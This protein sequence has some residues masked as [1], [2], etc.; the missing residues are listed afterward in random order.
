M[1]HKQKDVS[2]II[3]VTVIR[4]ASLEERENLMDRLEFVRNQLNLLIEDIK[5]KIKIVSEQVANQVEMAECSTTIQSGINC[6]RILSSVCVYMCV[7]VCLYQVSNAM[8]D[9]ICRLSVLIDEFHS[10]FHPSPHVLK[11]YKSVS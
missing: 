8:A 11:G 4:V 10:D 2:V 6:R 7:S 9:E 3:F 5:K 1:M